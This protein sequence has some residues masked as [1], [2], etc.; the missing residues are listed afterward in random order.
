MTWFLGAST[1]TTSDALVL[2]RGSGETG[3]RQAVAEASHSA[4]G[5]MS[6]SVAIQEMVPHLQ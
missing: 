2:R 6:I 5:F 4:V 3:Y 1:V